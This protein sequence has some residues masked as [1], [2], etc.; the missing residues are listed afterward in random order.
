MLVCITNML[1]ITSVGEMR[2]GMDVW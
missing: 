1:M 2:T